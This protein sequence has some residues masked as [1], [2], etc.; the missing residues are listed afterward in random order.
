ME[1]ANIAISFQWLTGGWK[2]CCH[3]HFTIN[4]MIVHETGCNCILYCHVLDLFMKYLHAK[5]E[6]KVLAIE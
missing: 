2:C 6:I 3:T 1:C 4:C 5:I